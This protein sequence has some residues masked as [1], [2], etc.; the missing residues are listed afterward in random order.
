MPKTYF[1][2]W[3]ERLR[4]TASVLEAHNSLCLAAGVPVTTP[5]GA[6]PPATAQARTAAA[7]AASQWDAMC[8]WSLQGTHDGQDVLTALRSGLYEYL[9]LLG[10]RA[11]GKSHEVAEALVDLCSQQRKRVVCGREFQNS[12]RDSSHAL[13]VQKIKKHA[14]VEDWSITDTE[15][16]HKNGTL[17]SFMGMARNPESAKSLEGADIFWGEEAQTFTSHS[18]EI[19]IPTIREHGSMLIFTANPRYADDPVPRMALVPAERPEALFYKFTCFEDNPYLFRSRLMN[20][21]RKSFRISKRF[22]HVWRGDLDRNSELRI[23]DYKVGTPPVMISGK[24]FYG[25]DFGGSDPTAFVR[26]W[27]WPS[28]TLGRKPEE[29]GILYIDREFYAPCKSNKDIVQG[30]TAVAPE[31]LTGKWI[32]K[33]DSADPK[34]IGELNN[35]TIPTHGAAKVAGSVLA[36][37]RTLADHEIWINADCPSAIKAAE[38]YRWKADNSG[39]PMNVP[40]HT[41]SHVWDAVRYAIE[42]E[43]LSGAG[44]VI[45]LNLWEVTDEE[46]FGNSG[47]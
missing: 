4:C 12:I 25:I 24:R 18:L 17:F 11:G 32:L 34:A 8:A 44:G 3:D 36:G 43:D 9:I 38:N 45:Y 23:I 40:D 19:L 16:R 27:H 14:S 6:L 5:P 46:I 15:L 2:P 42:D 13:L 20:D 1:T 28:K 31:L 10:G 30:V 26:L 33:A 22:N 37:L 41:F 47:G 35:A 39:K 29:K 21:L 7:L